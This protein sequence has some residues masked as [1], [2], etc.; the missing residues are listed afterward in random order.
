MGEKIVDGQ[1]AKNGESRDEALFQENSGRLMTIKQAANF[2]GIAVWAVRRL[3]WDRKIPIVTFGGPKVYIDR[4]DLL[5][6]IEQSKR[7]AD[8]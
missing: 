2:M 6:L 4:E 8:N 7:Y 1:G 3:V 5:V